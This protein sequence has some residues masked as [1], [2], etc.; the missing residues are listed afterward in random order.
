MD[1]LAV[2]VPS[3]RA[4]VS[5]PGDVQDD[6]TKCLAQT[7]HIRLFRETDWTRNGL[8]PLEE[9]DPTLR[10]FANFVFADSRAACLW[11][12]PDSV[13]I[14]N[15]AF[16]PLCQGVHPTLMGSTYA[17]G[18][19]ELWPHIRAMF[20]ES[21][22]TGIGQNVTSD[23]PLLVE[24]NGWKEEAFFSGSFI[25]IGPSKCPLGF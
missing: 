25:P 18:L 1:S 13:A 3:P 20:Q 14:Y 23:A 22:R 16:A 8:G 4:S 12:G 11:W 10:L 19:P 9:W 2:P 17:Q 7:D 24:R 15:D 5:A 6:W 21:S